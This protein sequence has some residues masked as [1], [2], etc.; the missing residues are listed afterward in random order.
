MAVLVE[1]QTLASHLANPVVAS[2]TEAA[3][4]A[5][6][7]KHAA[8]LL[9]ADKSAAARPA[10]EVWMWSAAQALPGISGPALHRFDPARAEWDAT[11]VKE[12]SIFGWYHRGACG[13]WS[14]PWSGFEKR[15][16]SR[17]TTEKADYRD[18]PLAFLLVSN[19]SSSLQSSVCR[20]PQS[21]RASRCRPAHFSSGNNP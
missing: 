15:S 20:L 11:L 2:S 4:I 13:L 10:R 9:A 16:R 18:A 1:L 14:R 21:I 19:F 17:R 12:M 7:A 6:V 8:K 5:R 3:A